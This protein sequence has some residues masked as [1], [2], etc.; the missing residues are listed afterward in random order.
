VYTASRAGSGARLHARFPNVNYVQVGEN[1][2]YA[3]GNNVGFAWALERRPD[4]IIVLNNDTIVDPDCISSLVRAARETGAALVAPKIVYCGAPSITWYA[5]GDFLPARALGR[6]R[7]EGALDDRSTAREQITFATGCCFAIRAD[8]LAQVGGFDESYFAYVEDAELSVRLRQA[9]LS[10]IYEPSARVLHRI[11]TGKPR[12]TPF[13]IRQ[14]DQNR[15][16]LVRAHYGWRSRLVF[17]CWYYPTRTLHLARYLLTG[18]WP[19]AKAIVIG[20]AGRLDHA[21]EWRENIQTRAARVIAR[22]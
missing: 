14:R 3:G 8:V 1:R 9:G 10:M 21:A 7:G 22:P 12:E 19:E 6:H 2:G 16:R 20:M 5:G 17:A 11:P 18:R 13:Q 15:R 4:F